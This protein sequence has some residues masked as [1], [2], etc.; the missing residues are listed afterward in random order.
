VEFTNILDFVEAIKADT[1]RCYANLCNLIDLRNGLSQGC[2]CSH[3]R[4]QDFFNNYYPTLPSKLTEEEKTF[5]KTKFN[6]S[7]IILKEN[8]VVIWEIV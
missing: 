1:E 3:Q 2:K 4:K 7:S 8:N 6:S 5:L